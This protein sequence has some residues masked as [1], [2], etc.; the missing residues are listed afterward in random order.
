MPKS[1]AE[2]AGIPLSP[3][4]SCA[5]PDLE[6]PAW[7]AWAGHV[8]AGRIGSRVQHSFDQRVALMRN[9]VA[10]FGRVVTGALERF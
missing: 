8:A 9:E 7:K 6:H 3:T 5:L 2:R 4:A 10:L 1:P